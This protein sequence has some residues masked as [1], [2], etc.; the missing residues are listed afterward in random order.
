MLQRYS[1]VMKV[2]IGQKKLP[3]EL[4]IKIGITACKPVEFEYCVEDSLG[5]VILKCLSMS[6]LSGELF[7]R[8]D[9]YVFHG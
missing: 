3:N 4:W 5:F 2:V 7:I 8:R 9:R 6:I 1:E